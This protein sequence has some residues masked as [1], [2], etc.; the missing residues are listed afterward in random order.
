[1]VGASFSFPSIRGRVLL[2]LLLILSLFATACGADSA[3]DDTANGLLGEPAD[4]QNDD[5][6]DAGAERRDDDPDT[7]D[8]DDGDDADVGDDRTEPIAIDDLPDEPVELE[9][10]LEVEPDSGLVIDAPGL[11]VDRDGDEVVV[12]E[13]VIGELD[14][15]NPEFL[16]ALLWSQGLVGRIGTAYGRDLGALGAHVLPDR[17]YIYSVLESENHFEFDFGGIEVDIPRNHVA[18][19]GGRS[20][21]VIDT[22]DLYIYVGGDCP[23]PASPVN[24]D[25][26]LSDFQGGCGFGFSPGGYIAADYGDVDVAP[27]GFADFRPQ[28]V[29]DGAGIPVPYGSVAGSVFVD[30]DPEKVRSVVHGEGSV[31][32]PGKAGMVVPLELPIGRLT[33]ATITRIDE[34]FVPRDATW[35][36]GYV[37]DDIVAAGPAAQVAELFTNELDVDVEAYFER[38]GGSVV[39]TWTPDTYLAIDASGAMSATPWIPAGMSV[40][41]IEGTF[42]GRFDADGLVGQG[43]VTSTPIPGVGISGTAAVAF[44]LP[45]DDLGATYLSIDGVLQ[46]GSAEL[47]DAGVRLGP[48]EIGVR[49]RVG[50]GSSFIDVAGSYTAA[51]LS[52]SGEASLTIDLTNLD[53]LAARIASDAGYDETIDRIEAELDEMAPHV[54]INTLLEEVDEAYEKRAINNDKIAGHEDDLAALKRQWDNWNLGQRI[55]NSIT[56][57]AQVAFH[58]SAIITLNTANATHALK[59]G[60]LDGIVDLY[61]DLFDPEPIDLERFR[62]LKDLLRE[63]KWE[64]LWSNIRN[65][66]AGI[67]RAADFL[68]EVFNLDARITGRALIEVSPQRFA[69]ELDVEFCHDGDCETVVG[70]TI[71]L[72][73]GDACVTF[74]GATGCT[75]L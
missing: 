45:F 21:I 72:P 7:D 17:L 46:V 59:I 61:D 63:L 66:L 57:G 19:G 53:D 12:T 55:A 35:L 43:S 49:G 62:A 13:T 64:R 24:I 40:G 3:A 8:P 22:Q 16:D 27:D 54:L 56:H 29:I 14:F 9:Q 23:G 65:V 33:A 68:L 41:R 73:Q 26:S 71:T 44:E 50:V 58:E 34:N 15:E 28:L 48:S 69:G 32:L 5:D 47:V 6:G 2:A 70:G 31:G 75:R 1:M 25:L 10:P 20:I 37:G 30:A 18:A 11:V 38:V 4:E 67:V 74:V 52:L 42:Q 60:A 36:R 51:G 39:P